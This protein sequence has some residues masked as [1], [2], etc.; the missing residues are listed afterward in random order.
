MMR[1]R[2]KLHDFGRAKEQIFV[3]ERIGWSLTMTAE[4]E[5]GQLI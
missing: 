3:K 1:Y 4:W 5:V 2:C